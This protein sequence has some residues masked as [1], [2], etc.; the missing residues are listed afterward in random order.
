MAEH[1]HPP[2]TREQQLLAAMKAM[3]QRFR[4]HCEG[5]D[6]QA[7]DIIDGLRSGRLAL[8]D[9]NAPPVAA[10]AGPTL[11]AA[12]L[13]VQDRKEAAYGGDYT[14][15]VDTA[16]FARLF[17]GTDMT[18][19]EIEQVGRDVTAGV[20]QHLQELGEIT[21]SYLKALWAEGVLTG[22]LWRDQRREVPAPDI[23]PGDFDQPGPRG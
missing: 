15:T 13:Q 6:A 10:T 5:C 9:T 14:S 4:G 16:T 17:V 19:A 1:Q 12:T 11:Q 3:H 22:I 8:V 7:A 18:A 21:P 20:I 23:A 2:L